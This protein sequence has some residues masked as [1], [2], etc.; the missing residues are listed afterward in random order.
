MKK[1]IL[2]LAAALGL[3]GGMAAQDGP[4]RLLVIDNNEQYKGFNLGQVKTIEFATIEGEVAAN[5]EM[6][7]SS[8]QEVHVKVTRTPECGQFMFDIVSG[9]MARQMLDNPAM[10]QS[11]LN[12]ISSKT[13]YE[14]FE[15]G[16]VTGINL[17]YSTEY[18]A[19]TLGFDMYGVACDV[20]AAFFTTEK[21]PI[22]GDP[23]VDVQLVDATTTTL[24]LKFTPNADVKEYYF[25][26]FGEGEAQQ[27]FDMFGPWMGLTSMADMIKRFSG[28]AKVGELDYEYKNMEANTKY[29]LYVA[30]ADKNGNLADLQIF[31]I[32]TESQGGSGTAYVEILAGDYVLADWNGEK[33][34]SQFFTFTPNDQTWCYRFGVWAASDYDKDPKGYEDYV[35][36]E[37]PMPNMANW[38]FYEAMTTDFQINPGETVVV[39]AAAKNA[40]GVWGET[41]TLRYTTGAMP[42]AAPAKVSASA[43]IAM[44]LAPYS[45]GNRAGYGRSAAGLRLIQSK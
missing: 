12:S 27:Q 33:M 30:P 23:K 36:S 21:A 39:I 31:P 25:C 18:A 7:S 35:A 1:Y 28:E 3:A 19:I 32:A 11:Y 17:E 13:Y 40:D 8:M 37:P 34:P 41:K 45:L 43:K 26:I 9:V 6:I 15:D 16:A 38:F 24:K 42:A 2:A 5:V 4:N 44:R 29:E 10:A 20:R 14:D 22:V